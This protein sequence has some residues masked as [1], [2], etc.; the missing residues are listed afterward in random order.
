[1]GKAGTSGTVSHC[2]TL[3]LQ[4]LLRCMEVIDKVGGEGG[5]RQRQRDRDTEREQGKEKAV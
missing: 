3:V 2:L 4:S 5:E 1:M